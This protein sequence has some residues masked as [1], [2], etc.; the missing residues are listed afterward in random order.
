MWFKTALGCWILSGALVGTLASTIT[1]RQDLEGETEATPG[2]DPCAVIGPKEWTTPKEVRACYKAVQVAPVDKIRDSIVDAVTQ[3]LDQYH[4]TYPYQ[5]HRKLE[6]ELARI[7][8]NRYKTGFDVHVDV[9]K[10]LKTG[11]PDGNVYYRDTCY[12]DLW[13][14]FIPT[15]LALLRDKKGREG[16]YITP[17]AWKVVSNTEEF[18]DQIEIWQNALPGKLKG[19]LAALSGAKVIKI[20]HQDPFDVLEEHARTVGQ[21]ESLDAREKSF[22][23][24]YSIN[25][26]LIST[27][28]FEFGDFARRAWPLDD[29]V[30]LTIERNGTNKEETITLPFRTRRVYGWFDSTDYLRQAWCVANAWAEEP[31]TNGKNIYPP[32][33]EASKTPVPRNGTIGLRPHGDGDVHVQERFIEAWGPFIARAPETPGNKMAVLTIAAFKSIG[34]W[35]ELADLKRHLLYV[36]WKTYSLGFTKLII[37]V[38]GNPGGDPCLAYYLERV[39]FGSSVKRPGPF[40]VVLRAPPLARTIVKDIS[41]NNA[42]PE[43][44]L[45]YNPLNFASKNGQLNSTT[46]YLKK[47]EKL[48]INGE[49]VE[50]SSKLTPVC[51]PFSEYPQPDEQPYFKPKDVVV[52]SDGRCRGVCASFVNNLVERY[53]IKT[54]VAGGRKGVQQTYGTS[55]GGLSL[56]FSQIKTDILSTGHAK[57]R[58]ALPDLLTNGHVGVTW[59]AALTLNGKELQ[60]N[61]VYK[62][63]VTIPL[64]ADNFNNQF[65]LW[66]Q[67]A[68]LLLK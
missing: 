32:Q 39:L 66:D 3:T 28:V 20:N 2:V 15:P 57:D 52:L 49:T 1:T 40:D 31:F 34:N 65:A 38:T 60:E 5:D 64:T 67:V 29:S 22:F 27:D 16:I 35:V 43:F 4:A 13:E 42:D 63:T 8:H 30:T 68:K 25:A 14:S 46:N 45:S 62:P 9:V 12:D 44:W 17:D 47:P 55:P 18:A 58:N 11:L 51:A 23:A 61:K 19:N 41:E 26:D 6:K 36:V 56:D 50:Y 21:Y 33:S 54:A 7:K 10:T 37:D 59:G 24:S 48:Y 53:G